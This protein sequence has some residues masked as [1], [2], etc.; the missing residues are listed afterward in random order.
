M[1][2]PKALFLIMSSVVTV[3]AHIP[4]KCSPPKGDVIINNKLILV[5]GKYTIIAPAS[6]SWEYT[7]QKDD[8]PIIMDYKKLYT[9]CNYKT[10]EHYTFKLIRLKAIEALNIDVIYGLVLGM[11]IGYSSKNLHVENF[12]VLNGIMLPENSKEFSYRV[13]D[14]NGNLADVNGCILGS[15]PFF[16]VEYI[17]YEN[18]V[19]IAYRAI[20]KSIVDENQL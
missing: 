18:Y 4:I 7:A 9:A 12:K 10:G 6:Y 19:P 3:E 15:N 16:C 1:R 20:L 14:H 8:F 11:T 2:L 17:S 5:D 13:N